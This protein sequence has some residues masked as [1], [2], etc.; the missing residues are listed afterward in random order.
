MNGIG[1]LL[2]LQDTGGFLAD[3]Y[4]K[5][6]NEHV[7]LG[8]EAGIT[9]KTDSRVATRRISTHTDGC[10]GVNGNPVALVAKHGRLHLEPHGLD[11][12]PPKDGVHLGPYHAPARH[13][14]RCYIAEG[15]AIVQFF[16]QISFKA[17]HIVFFLGKCSAC[18]KLVSKA[19]VDE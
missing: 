15:V 16:D 13:A 3:R 14:K 12:H 2:G 19:G 5:G 9:H 6:I 17:D 7:L 11:Q 10:L 8:K 4:T 1:H 18:F